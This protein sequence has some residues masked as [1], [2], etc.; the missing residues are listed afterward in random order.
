MTKEDKAHKEGIEKSN[1]A[2][3]VLTTKSW[4]VVTSI[5]RSS[6][7]TASYKVAVF[8]L[9]TRSPKKPLSKTDSIE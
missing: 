4:E 1:D 6:D 8:T 9:S 3:I 2:Y 7:G 5:L